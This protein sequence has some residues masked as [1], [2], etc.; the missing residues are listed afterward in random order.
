MPLDNPVDLTNLQNLIVE[1]IAGEI[2][3]MIGCGESPFSGLINGNPTFTS[4]VYAGETNEDML[5][6]LASG[7]NRWGRIILHNTTRSSSRK[8]VSVNLVTNTI[9][10]EFS[11]DMWANTDV[12]TC[13]SQTNT[14]AS[15]FDVD[16]SGEIPTTTS[17]I[18]MFTVFADNE[19]NYDS[20]R[21]I[22]FH[23]YEAYDAGK[24]QWIHARQANDSHGATLPIK[25]VDQ[26]FTMLIGSGSVDVTTVLNVQAYVEPFNT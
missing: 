10:T 20:S 9:T 18:F 15:Y 3:R 14:T 16:V 13:Q 24:R 25:I 2:L 23:P 7:A 17:A 26:K 1:P 11:I 12:I 8:I 21:Y 22:M 4:V 6:G 19:G 5:K